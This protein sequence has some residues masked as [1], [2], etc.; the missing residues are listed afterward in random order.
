M[1]ENVF[2]GKDNKE[3]LVQLRAKYRAEPSDS[4]AIELVAE[5]NEQDTEGRN[6]FAIAKPASNSVFL[7]PNEVPA[8]AIVGAYTAP[9]CGVTSIDDSADEY[10]SDQMDDINRVITALGATLDWEFG[11]HTLRSLTS[12][13]ES[14][15]D[16]GVQEF[17]RLIP[18]PVASQQQGK[19]EIGP[20][21]AGVPPELELRWCARIHRWNLLLGLLLRHHAAE[22][23]FWRSHRSGRLQRLHSGWQFLSG[24]A[25]CSRRNQEA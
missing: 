4:F 22:H 10:C 20:D 6:F 1:Q 12:Y 25:L 19:H 16:L 2:L 23:E 17:S 21:L 9:T 18:P 11:N 13:R 14:D 5:Y 15:Q 7:G 3:D 24:S 8:E